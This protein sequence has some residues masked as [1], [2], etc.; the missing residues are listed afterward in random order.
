MQLFLISEQ[1]GG[2]FP[3]FSEHQSFAA[4][5]FIT[6][7]FAGFLLPKQEPCQDLK[8]TLLPSSTI[9]DAYSPFGSLWLLAPVSSQSKVTL[10]QIMDRFA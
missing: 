1:A 10:R 6:E 2:G 3:H 9:V 8:N 5:L 4:D 7:I